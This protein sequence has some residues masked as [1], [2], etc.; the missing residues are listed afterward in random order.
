M[1]L[2]TFSVNLIG[3]CDSDQDKEVVYIQGNDGDQKEKC[4]K[5]WFVETCQKSCCVK[6]RPTEEH[7]KVEKSDSSDNLQCDQRNK[8]NQKEK[9]KQACSKMHVLFLTI[10]LN[11]MILALVTNP[12]ANIH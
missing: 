6:A 11:L 12:S 1:C 4:N 8:K 9:G 7:R 3:Y 5:E 2:D 10:T